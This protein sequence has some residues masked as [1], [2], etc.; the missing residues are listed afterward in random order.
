M[1]KKKLTSVA[2]KI[3]LS[4]DPAV[5]LDEYASKAYFAADARQ[6]KAKPVKPFPLDE[7][8]RATVAEIPSLPANLKKKLAKK[9]A[10]FTIVESISMM[11]AMSESFEG[12]E[13]K[14]Q[15]AL[16]R[17]AKK[18]INCLQENIAMPELPT[19]TKKPKPTDA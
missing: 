16:L 11:M 14:Q 12:N 19:K 1:A 7:D 17:V 13:P 6:I 4:A 5:A 9:D 10:A 3:K 18:L 8:E 15:V 2:K